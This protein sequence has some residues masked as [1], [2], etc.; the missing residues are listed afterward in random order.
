M[1][2]LQ[3][4]MIVRCIVSDTTLPTPELNPD[5]PKPLPAPKPLPEEKKPLPPKP[6]EKPLPLPK[7]GGDEPKGD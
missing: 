4:A 6:I 2:Y 1:L 3:P 5:D 7:P